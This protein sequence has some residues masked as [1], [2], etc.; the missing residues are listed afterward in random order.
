MGLF[1]K[2]KGASETERVI[3]EVKRLT[4]KETITLSFNEKENTD[5]LNSKLGGIPYWKEGADYPIDSSGNAMPLL[6]QVNLSEIPYE[7]VLPDK[8]MLQIF[9]ANNGSAECRAV[10]YNV[11]EDITEIET[12]TMPCGDFS[13]VLKECEIEFSKSKDYMCVNDNEFNNVLKK[14]VKSVSGKDM[15][16]DMYDYF[17]EEECEMLCREFTAKGSKLFGNPCFTQCDIRD[18][19][20]DEVLLLQLDS[21]GE[22][23]MWG[24][25][26]VGSFFIK[27]DDLQNFDFENV[28]YGWDCY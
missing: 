14:A 10:F 26:G 9:I 23:I 4:E 22:S 24:D 3:D 28:L 27:K 17:S 15:Q 25:F 6:I 2:L 12:K 8:G 5:P 16:G 11:L 20:S 19:G 21:D 7:T 18:A 1:T 13:P